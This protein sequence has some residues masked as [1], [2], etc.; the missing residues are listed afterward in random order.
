VLGL[1]ACTTTARLEKNF[2]KR[3]EGKRRGRGN[4]NKNTQ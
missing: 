3:E 4:E 2:N 1:K